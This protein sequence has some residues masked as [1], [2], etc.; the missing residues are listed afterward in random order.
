[1]A[2]QA[3]LALKR[4]FIEPP[5]LKLSDFPKAFTIE[6]DAS[7]VDLGAILMYEGHP[8]SFYSKDLI[9]K[10]LLLSTYEKELLALVSVVSKWR[11]YL[12]GRPFKIK[13]DQ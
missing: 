8:I 2:T 5:V 13:T 4:A 6:C 1:M 10:A 12:L 3:F 7:S 9:G 11:P